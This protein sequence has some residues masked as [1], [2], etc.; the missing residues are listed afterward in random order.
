MAAKRVRKSKPAPKNQL[1]KEHNEKFDLYVRK[2]LL[3]LNMNDWRFVR[4]S[5]P[6][7][8]MA[9]ISKISM[10]DR[11]AHYRVG[12]DFGETE[13][14]DESLENIALHEV[15]HV[16]LAPLIYEVIAYKEENKWTMEKEHSIIIVLARL[17]TKLSDYAAQS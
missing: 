17:L 4:H 10:T 9:E 3:L 16:F 13:V 2:W 1:T 5:T 14:N 12:K 7:A 11:L 8:S 15:L 6:S